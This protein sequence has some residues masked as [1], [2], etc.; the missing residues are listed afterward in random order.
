ME[1]GSKKASQWFEE[2]NKKNKKK[3]KKKKKKKRK[4]KK[5]KKSLKTLSSLTKT[6]QLLRESPSN[7]KEES[8][9]AQGGTAS[10]MDN[11]L[12]RRERGFPEGIHGKRN[13]AKTGNCR[14][15]KK[16]TF[17][18]HNVEELRQESGPT[19]RRGFQ[20][21]ASEIIQAGVLSLRQLGV[22]TNF[23]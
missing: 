18:L 7:R 15:R 21:G 13:A 23:Q 6:T 22:Q 1:R 17:T 14:R 5:K 20:K 11:D 12:N 2:T 4:K 10:S 19:S 16:K 9:I 8:K 3:K